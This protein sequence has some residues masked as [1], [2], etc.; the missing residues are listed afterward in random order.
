VIN[1]L[2][3]SLR[4]F[5]ADLAEVFGIGQ[6]ALQ[7]CST[8]DD[9]A[10]HQHSLE[11]PAE[12]NAFRAKCDANDSTILTETTL[13]ERVQAL[14]RPTN[15]STTPFVPSEEPLSITVIVRYSP[16]VESHEEHSRDNFRASERGC[17]WE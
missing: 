15:E 11:L 3:L 16:W 1:D 2:V 7:N 17:R 6:Q 12:G 10:T 9:V 8:N 5:W 4:I 13:V 14:G